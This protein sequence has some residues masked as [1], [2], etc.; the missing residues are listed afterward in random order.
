[1]KKELLVMGLI[2]ILSA[3][4][5]SFFIFLINNSEIPEN[6]EITPN[7]VI[8]VIDG[9]TFEIYNSLGN[10][11][12]IRLLCVDT[13]EL[14]QTGYEEAKYYLE[15]LVLNKQVILHRSVTDK[16]IYNRLLRYVYINNSGNLLF[17]NKLIL[18]NNYGKLMVI[19]PEECKEMK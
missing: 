5:V 15:T 17:I 13:P 9:D 14:N 10:I 19:P 18:D 8:Q 12:T 1:M 16:D 11:E 2:L 6:S 7:T 3:I 4:F